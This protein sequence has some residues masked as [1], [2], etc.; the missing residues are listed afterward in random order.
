M[1]RNEERA[2]GQKK[3]TR[4]GLIKVLGLSHKREKQNGPR[5]AWFT[6][7]RIYCMFSDIKNK[8]EINSALLLTSM[9][10]HKEVNKV[11]K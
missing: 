6:F 3:R 8:E 7:H 10:E 11:N 9:S 5:L 2:E 4:T 1:D